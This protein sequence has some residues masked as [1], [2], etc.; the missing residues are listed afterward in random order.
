[1]WLIMYIFHWQIKLAEL[2][3]QEG[4]D[5]IQTEGGKYSS[6]SKAGILGLIEKVTYVNN[7]T[8]LT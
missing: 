6:P 2:L 1:M 7:R 4:G 5:I 3:E 8:S